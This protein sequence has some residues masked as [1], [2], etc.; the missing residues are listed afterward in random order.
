MDYRYTV[1]KSVDEGLAGIPGK[2]VLMF[3]E[4]S[5]IEVRPEEVVMIDNYPISIPQGDY[6]NYSYDE[7]RRSCDCYGTVEG[8][9]QFNIVCYEPSDDIVWTKGN[10]DTNAPFKDWP[11]V[12]M[13]FLTKHC[14]RIE[15]IEA[16]H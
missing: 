11:E 9:K 3:Q 14:D 10:T 7:G 8:A 5:A 12:L 6:V 1:D 15:L 4:G 13:F 2:L 16:V